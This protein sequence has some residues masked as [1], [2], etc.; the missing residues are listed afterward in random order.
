MYQG[1]IYCIADV[2]D[3]ETNKENLTVFQCFIDFFSGCVCFLP[4]IDFSVCTINWAYSEPVWSDLTSL[5]AEVAD[6]ASLFH[7]V[8]K[9]GKE[10]DR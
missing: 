9:G 4:V 7:C 1:C 8:T 2:I 10:S 3:K 6:F 5:E